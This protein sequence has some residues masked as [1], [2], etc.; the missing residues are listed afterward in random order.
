M[1]QRQLAA[2]MVETFSVPAKQVTM[3]LFV[4]IPVG[5][6]DVHRDRF[7]GRCFAHNAKF[8]NVTQFPSAKV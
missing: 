6:Y 8:S 2:I 3:K 7:N 5:T 4:R 1:G